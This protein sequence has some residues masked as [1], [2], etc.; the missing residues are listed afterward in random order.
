[1]I[2]MFGESL[3]LLLLY[4]FCVCVKICVSQE[5]FDIVLVLFLIFDNR[6]I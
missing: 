1:M 2:M 4:F 5:R 3:F 6:A